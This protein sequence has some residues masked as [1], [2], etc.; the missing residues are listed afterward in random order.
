MAPPKPVVFDFN[1]G[2]F[3]IYPLFPPY[4]WK[5]LWAMAGQRDHHSSKKNKL[6]VVIIPEENGENG[7]TFTAYRW[8]FV[9]GIAGI[10]LLVAII[11]VAAIVFT[12]V[13]RLIPVSDAELSLRYGSELVALQHRVTSLS[14]EMLVMRDYNRKLRYALGDHTDTDSLMSGITEHLAEAPDRPA[15]TSESLDTSPQ[16][17]TR[18]KST[19]NERIAVEPSTPEAPLAQH[20]PAFRAAFPISAPVDGYITRTFQTEKLHFGVDYAGKRGTIVTAAA[21]G[22]VIFS[23]WTHDAGNIIIISHGSGYVTVYQHNEALLKQ[24]GDFVKR[25]TPIALLGDSG[26]TSYGPHLH[27]ELWKDGQ[28]QDPSAYLIASGK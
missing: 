17:V 20:S 10:F 12:P 26:T 15:D 13:G 16:T 5:K 21:D 24:Q 6:Q 23:N 25:G 27:F 8:E 22:Y 11:G 2:S 1:L 14:Q 9:A 28:P 7:F 18:K 3:Y 19:R 4:N